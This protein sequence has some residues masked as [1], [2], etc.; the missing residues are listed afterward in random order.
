MTVRWMPAL[1]SVVVL[2]L[3]AACVPAA[4]SSPLDTFRWSATFEGPPGAVA[5]SFVVVARTAGWQ[6]ERAGADGRWSASLQVE[7]CGWLGIGTYTETVRAE[8]SLR[9]TDAAGTQATLVLD[10][11]PEA[12]AFGASV[13]E[14]LG[15]R[16]LSE[17]GAGMG[18]TKN[19]PS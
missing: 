3:L 9:P 14:T 8:L 7:R 17:P 12:V 1:A 19:H 2:F 15:A 13:R 6:V 11:V 10:P 16:W 18:G 5:S 4:G